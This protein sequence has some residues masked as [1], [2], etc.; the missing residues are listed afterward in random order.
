MF[1]IVKLSLGQ[2]CWMCTRYLCVYSSDGTMG[3][4]HACEQA[5][6]ESSC[7][8]GAW[9]EAAG[10]WSVSRTA[11]P[12]NPPT[13]LFQV[14]PQVLPQMQPELPEECRESPRHAPLP[15]G[16]GESYPLQACPFL[17]G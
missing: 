6:A 16:S 7:W 5:E 10:S 2:L 12:L 9:Q 14:L 11:R 4:V 17:I 1:C 3:C 13:S 15:G 8:E